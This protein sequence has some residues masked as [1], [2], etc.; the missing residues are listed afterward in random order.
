MLNNIFDKILKNVK[1][2]TFCTIHF[3]FFIC[4]KCVSKDKII[5]KEKESVEM[6][7]I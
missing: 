4:D 2:H 6:L 1:Y 3:V 5:F 7:F